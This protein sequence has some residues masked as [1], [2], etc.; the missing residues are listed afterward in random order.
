MINKNS[1]IVEVIREMVESRH[2]IHGV[3]CYERGH[4]VHGWGNLD[5]S[6]YPR[7]TIKPM[8]ALPLIETGADDTASAS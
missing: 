2:R 8:Q 1:I 3:V 7:S 5:L 6:I 4:V